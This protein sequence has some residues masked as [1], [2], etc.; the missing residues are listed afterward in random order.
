MTIGAPRT[1]LTTDSLST[2]LLN[3]EVRD[4]FNALVN[5]PR[6]RVYKTASFTGV[7]GTW[8]LIVF[9]GTTYVQSYT[10]TLTTTP[11][12]RLIAPVAG[13]YTLNAEIGWTNTK[14]VVQLTQG[15]LMIRKN[16]AG[17]STGGSEVTISNQKSPDTSGTNGSGVKPSVHSTGSCHLSVDIPMAANDYVQMFA[18]QWSSNT[19][20]WTPS[21]LVGG[22]YSTWMDLLWVANLPTLL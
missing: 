13:L 20:G 17:S 12:D 16:S 3:A 15:G 10:G 9:D 2:T 19:A 14:G 5:P 4:Q 21:V 18:E 7:N 22:S 6:A 8:A 11:N 1:W